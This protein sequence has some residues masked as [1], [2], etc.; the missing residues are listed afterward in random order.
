MATAHDFFIQ[1]DH[2]N[3]RRLVASVLQNEG[4]AVTVNPVGGLIARRGSTTAT[5]LFGG[6]AGKGLQQT[7]TVDFMIDVDGR[8]VARLNRNMAGGVLKGGAI[9]AVKTDNAF[10]QIANAI[11]A[12][13]H[14]AGVLSGSVSQG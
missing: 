2:E 13:L 8:L 1:G 5:I 12:A 7:F 14:G 10:Q 4:F 11:G 3:G 9:G 6:L